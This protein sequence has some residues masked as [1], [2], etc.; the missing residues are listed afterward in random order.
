MKKTR[1]I[2]S[3]LCLFAL[4]SCA[5]EKTPAEVTDSV[6][7]TTEETTAE[8]IS[9]DL[10][11]KNY[12]GYDFTMY[13]RG[14]DKFIVDMYTESD[15]DIMNDAI[16][17]RN[18]RVADRFG[19]NFILFRGNNINGDDAKTPILA[20]EDAYD[21]VVCHARTT[22]SLAHNDLLLEWNTDLPYINLDKPWWNNDAR[23]NL[24]VANKLYTCAGDISYQNLGATDAM[25]FN[26]KL[27]TELKIEGIYDIVRNGKWTF[28]LFSKY[29]R[30]GSSDLDSDGVLNLETDRLGYVTTQWIGPIQVLYSGS[31]RICTKD[32]NDELVLSLNTERTV[33]IFDRFFALLDSGDADVN[34]DSN[35]YDVTTKAFVENR[36]LFCDMNIKGISE[37]RDMK[38]DFG[39][40]PW[41]KFDESVDKYYSNVD[42]GCNLIGVPKTVS[43]PERSSIIIE[44]LC[45]D[46]H[47]N[48]L[49]TYYE[50]A[51][52]TKYTRDDDSV[53]MLD[54]IR[55]GRVFDAGYFYSGNYLCYQINSIGR[56]LASE[57]ADHNFSTFY[58][59]YESTAK[60]ML[61]QVNETY[62]DR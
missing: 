62:R 52:Q 47:Y 35:K 31:Q 29:V 36:A 45:A 39:I 18:S 19:V 5:A 41:P 55:E 21:I 57:A 30:E 56:F 59:K 3:M 13:I 33:E 32:K 40:I 20:G 60:T 2:S 10:P 54:L 12:E 49:P 53:Q 50:V 8:R 43:D 16:F 22:S 14:D 58:A 23:E 48:I 7:T 27:F 24:S 61:E 4:T 38:A 17:E 46:G 51:L 1:L 6:V 11:Q 34:I 26:K 9:D 37:L 42:A 44:A 28:D 15:G 25:L